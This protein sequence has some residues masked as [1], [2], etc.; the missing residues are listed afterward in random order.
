MSQNNQKGPKPIPV[1][2]VELTQG[3][4]AVQGQIAQL[5]QHAN[6]VRIAVDALVQ[7]MG[8]EEVQRVIDEQHLQRLTP[9]AE[10]MKETTLKALEEGKIAVVDTVTDK[11][12]V[13]AVERN[14]RNAITHLRAQLAMP[15]V[16][17]E[18]QQKL[19]GH[20]VGDVV[21]FVHEQSGARVTF[22]ILE[23]YEAVEPGDK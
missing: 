5:Q 10:K 17:D 19:L 11:S 18:M 15:L 9:M 6:Y 7:L 8:A 2:V 16:T 13:I 1:Q 12:I 4:N 20:K 22:E 21:E 3:L 23:I 14:E